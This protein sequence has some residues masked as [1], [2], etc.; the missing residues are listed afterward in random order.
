METGW[1]ELVS[2]RIPDW[3]PVLQ[4]DVSSGHQNVLQKLHEELYNTTKK[5]SAR[6]A[7]YSIIHAVCFGV[8]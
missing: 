3:I 2:P 7:I 5:H 1:D 4:L 6:M 8:R